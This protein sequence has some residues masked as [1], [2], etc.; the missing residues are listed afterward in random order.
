MLKIYALPES[1]PP[2]SSSKYAPTIAY[3]SDIE[4]DQPN[5]SLT[6]VS[7][8]F[9]L[10]KVVIIN[11]LLELFVILPSDF[12]NTNCPAVIG[13]A[14]INWFNDWLTLPGTHSLFALFHNNACPSDG[15]L[16][17]VSTSESEFILWFVI[18]LIWPV[19]FVNSVLFISNR[20]FTLLYVKEALPSVPKS[21]VIPAPS[22]VIAFVEPFDNTIFLSSI[23]KSVL[24]IVVVVPF[25]CKLPEMI[26]SPTFPL[27]NLASTLASV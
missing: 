7:Y 3:D 18:S 26:T 1:V 5:L 4:T 6:D 25:T 21:I 24:L 14:V 19:I 15:A 11:S 8:A 27:A 13:D 22:L 9:G 10:S 12:K 16:E 17:T 20:S 2:A 23:I